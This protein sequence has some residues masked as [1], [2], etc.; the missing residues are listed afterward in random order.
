[1]WGPVR[2][3][4]TQTQTAATAT[5]YA[6]LTQWAR[7]LPGRPDGPGR[8][9]LCMLSLRAGRTRHPYTRARHGGA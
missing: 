2:S 4:V 9:P 7:S 8:V 1:M 5:G 6:V 3:V